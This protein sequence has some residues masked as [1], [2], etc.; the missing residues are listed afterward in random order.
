M[1]Y[2]RR[3]LNASSDLRVRNRIVVFEQSPVDDQLAASVSMPDAGG[4]V[5]RP[6]FVDVLLPFPVA[7]GVAF[8]L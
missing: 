7:L 8:P 5:L 1:A 3:V 4:P 6:K 2:V